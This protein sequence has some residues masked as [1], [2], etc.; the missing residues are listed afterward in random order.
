MKQ[1]GYIV[2]INETDY[3][4]MMS[5]N[6]RLRMKQFCFPECI[7]KQSEAIAYMEW[8][9]ETESCGESLAAAICYELSGTES[10]FMLLAYEDG[11]K[12]DLRVYFENLS[13]RNL[14]DKE[15]TS[16]GWVNGGT[17]RLVLSRPEEGELHR[18]EIYPDYSD[19]IHTT[20]ENE[21]DKIKK[22]SVTWMGTI[23]GIGSIDNLY[24]NDDCYWEECEITVKG[25]PGQYLN[26]TLT[27]VIGGELTE[28]SYLKDIYLEGEQEKHITVPIG[29]QTTL[30]LAGSVASLNGAEARADITLTG[31]CKEINP[32][33]GQEKE[34]D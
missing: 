11:C 30:I 31:T 2:L 5:R 28:E 26:C 29:K 4:W 9:D 10:S 13:A 8:E 19:S 12:K 17:L 3:N 22:T 27:L 25:N 20:D 1:E 23:Y 34:P 18:L 32:E 14:K 6:F 33:K 24:L 7:R 15:M 16:L 21:S